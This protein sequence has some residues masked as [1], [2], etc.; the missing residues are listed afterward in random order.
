M[1]GEVAG[2]R[3]RVR[4]L[5]PEDR[6]RKGEGV[7][8]KGRVNVEVAE[9]DVLCGGRCVAAER[10]AGTHD[11]ALRSRDPRRGSRRSCDDAGRA[12]GLVGCDPPCG[13]D[14]ESAQHDPDEPPDSTQHRRAF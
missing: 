9:E 14:G 10:R 7:D 6:Q 13:D 12:I 1:T 4:A 5:A 3:R 11:G 2:V 8:G